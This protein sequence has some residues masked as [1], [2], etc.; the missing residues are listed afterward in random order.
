MWRSSILQCSA[1]QH[2][3][4][5][6]AVQCSAVQCSAVQCSAVQCSAVQC[7]AVQCWMEVCCRALYLGH[8]SLPAY[9]ALEHNTVKT[10]VG[11]HRI[12]LN[13][14]KKVHQFFFLFQFAQIHNYMQVRKYIQIHK[15]IQVRT[16]MQELGGGC[17]EFPLSTM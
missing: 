15:Y 9:M 8:I 10:R 1:V 7:S 16:N 12:E 13:K 4:E 6:T 17:G 2:N 14:R 5:E 11:Q 3:M